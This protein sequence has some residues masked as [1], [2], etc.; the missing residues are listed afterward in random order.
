MSERRVY[1]Y[2]GFVE[3]L[4]SGKWVYDGFISS[5]DYDICETYASSKKAA[6]K[7]I[8]YKYV[9]IKGLDGSFASLYRLSSS[10]FTYNRC[11]ETDISCEED[12]LDCEE[13]Q[14]ILYEQMTLF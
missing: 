14:S 5:K 10:P 6:S 4:C 11:F 9:K 1:A 7:N 8:V 13:S 12:A 2:N 3:K